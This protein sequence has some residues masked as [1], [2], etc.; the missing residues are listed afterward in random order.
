VR[1]ASPDILVSGDMSCLMHLSGLAEKEGRPIRKMH[2]IQILRD[3]LR[4]G[5][6]IA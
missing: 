2:F 4:N 1:E 5:G 6:L 3:A